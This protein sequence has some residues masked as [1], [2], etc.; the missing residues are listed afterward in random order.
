MG[1]EITQVQK[2]VTLLL[3]DEENRKMCLSLFAEALN[4][5]DSFGSNKWGAYY[6]SDGIGIRLLVGNLIVFTIHR[7]EIWLALDKEM[8]NESKA[9][10]DVLENARSWRWDT[11]R[12]SEYIPV[13]SRNG[14]YVPS[15]DN[16]LIWSHI[17][18]LHF[19]YVEK[20]AKK[21]EWL[22]I[23]SQRKHSG[24]L[25]NYIRGEL[26]K[27]IPNPNYNY[28]PDSN[29]IHDIEEFKE[30]FR[31]LTDTE[32]ESIVQSRI[33]QGE[34]RTNLIK[35][36]EKCSVTGCELLRV[37]K[38][39]HIKPWRCSDNIERLDKFNGLLLIPNLD[40]AFDTGLISFDNEGKI[41]ISNLLGDNDRKELGI[42]TKLHIRKIET[43]H[44]KYLEYHR[45][46]VFKE[47]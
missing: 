38:A 10:Q 44:I 29:P 9:K 22:N 11:G 17:R 42:H 34:F 46:N 12:Y 20:V 35:Y 25:L 45:R 6:R 36:W 30:D 41:L 21:Y 28:S 40:S 13:P 14:Y 16:L 4:K 1:S 3:P 8:L 24:D 32:R 19:A 37:L 23:R 43:P 27:D 15:E 2:I 18:D 31:E 26:E 33:G 39:S 47:R 5:A 7:G